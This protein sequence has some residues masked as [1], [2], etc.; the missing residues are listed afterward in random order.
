MVNVKQLLNT[1]SDSNWEKSNLQNYSQEKLWEIKDGKNLLAKEGMKENANQ[2]LRFIPR[3]T[4]LSDMSVQAQSKVSYLWW[5]SFTQR[6]NTPLG[7]TSCYTQATDQNVG[8][9][10]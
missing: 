1:G 8:D 2:G 5:G 10:A 7:P 4:Q 3:A 9:H 6:L